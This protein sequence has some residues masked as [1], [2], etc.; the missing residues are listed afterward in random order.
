MHPIVIGEYQW[1][2]NHIHPKESAKVVDNY[3]LKCTE[4]SVRDEGDLK[5]PLKSG[6]A[7][8]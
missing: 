4:K 2:G 1:K 3:A 5:Q 8:N 6:G 7:A